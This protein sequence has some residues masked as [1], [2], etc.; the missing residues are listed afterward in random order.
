[1]AEKKTHG[2]LGGDPFFFFWK[3]LGGD[4]LIGGRF[5]EGSFGGLSWRLSFFEHSGDFS[6]LSF[7]NDKRSCYFF[8]V[9]GRALF[10]RGEL[11]TSLV[12]RSFSTLIG[13]YH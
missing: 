3:K 4:F 1:M 5:L 6:S 10:W 7:L 2:I 11:F 8:W 9:A 12:M 13:I